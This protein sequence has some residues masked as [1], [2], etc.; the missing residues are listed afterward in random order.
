MD[1]QTDLNSTMRQI[2]VN[3]LM[4]VANDYELKSGTIFLAINYVD[5]FLSS[6]SVVRN[7][8]QLVGI[9]CLLIAW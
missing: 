8:L 9:S 7:K 2:L 1:R 5:R 6:M 3:W 4:E